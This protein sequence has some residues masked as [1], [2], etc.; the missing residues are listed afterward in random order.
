[1]ETDELQKAQV[2]DMIAD[3]F[4]SSPEPTTSD[5]VVEPIV[6]ETKDEANGEE[7]KDNEGE[8]K[9]EEVSTAEDQEGESTS[10]ESQ[11]V[12]EVK[13]E[14]P[15]EEPKEDEIT[16]IRKQNEMLLQRIEELSGKIMEPAKQ[17]EQQQQDQTKSD[18]ID[19]VGEDDL[20]DI[21]ASKELFNAAITKAM[22][23]AEERAI[24]KILVSIPHIVSKHTQ[25]QLMIKQATDEFYRDN[26]DLEPV[27]KTVAA[28]ANEIYSTNPQLSV[29][30]IFQKSAEKT[31]EILGLRKQALRTVNEQGRTPELVRRPQGGREKTKVPSIDKMQQELSDLLNF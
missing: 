21:L 13:T 25:Q 31:R 11:P 1:M 12:E 24:Q 6:E 10:S 27:K 9:E 3:F 7:S 30:E 19:I 20:D 8:V 17:P 18:I 23:V 29:V 16:S 22:I 15:K 28:V 5:E 26:P 2:A 4:P 14:I